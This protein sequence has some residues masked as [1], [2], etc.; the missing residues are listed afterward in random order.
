MKHLSSVLVDNM[1]ILV[2][3]IGVI[4]AVWPSTLT[5][6]GP[7][8]PWM[9]GIVM[10]G[11]GMTL[12]VDDF[13]NVFRR[14]QL[15]LIGIFAQ[16]FIMPLVAWALVRIFAL[17]PEIAI[18][19]ILV[20]TCPGGT[21]SNVISYLARG[22]VAL[23]VSMS[24]ATTILAPVVTPALTWL[25]AGAWIEVSFTAMMISIAEMVLLPLLLGL[26]L[27][28]FCRCAV[29]HVLPHMPLLSVTAIVLLVGGVVALSASKLMDV[30][31]LLF[32][33][34]VLHNGFGL[35]FGYVMAHLFHLDSQK[36]RTIAIEVGMRNS[37]MAASLAVL[38]FNPVAAIPG[39]IFSVWHNVSGSILANFFARRDERRTKAIR[40]QALADTKQ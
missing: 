27:N 13:R 24:M 25:L 1:A 10:L 6:V 19:V 14:P 22:D 5:W 11:M 17:P 29:S 40:T 4:G 18:G 31:L 33:I 8:I 36:A 7:H 39:A 3:L 9:L 34:V 30:G 35:F 28:H 38:Y 20:G 23:S 12:S 21:A 16:F 15:V 32:A 37:G 26:C 2:V